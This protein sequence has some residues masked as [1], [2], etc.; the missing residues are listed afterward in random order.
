MK[1]FFR[2]AALVAVVFGFLAQVRGQTPAAIPATAPT[3]E[4]TTAPAPPPPYRLIMPPGMQQVKVGGRVAI[5]PAAMVAAVT[6]GLGTVKPSSRPSTM[7]SDLLTRLAASRATIIAQMSADL[8]IPQDKVATFLDGPLKKD[9]TELAGINAKIYVIVATQADVTAAEKAGWHAPLFYY[10]AMADQTV[11]Q[12]RVSVPLDR[13]MDDVV[14]WTPVEA[15]ATDA[16]IAD[17]LDRTIQDFETG[18]GES[19]AEDG[20]VQTRDDMVRFIAEEVTKNLKVPVDG[21][22]FGLG[23]LGASSAKYMALMTGIPRGDLA[24]AAASDSQS[25]PVKPGPIDLMHPIAPTDI[26]PE[27]IPYYVDAM[28]RKGAG[29]VEYLLEKSKSGD[30]V[31][32]KLLKAINTQQPADN[33]ALLKIIQD[34]SGVDLSG[35]L[36]PK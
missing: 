32:P 28:S 8:N 35:E 19:T 16:D 14:L 11:Y 18:F 3:T 33:A 2:V 26:K 15:S 6:K 36:G 1:R 10:N 9:L 24:A 21:D 7:P 17:A 20:L 22:W 12:P 27:Y 30:A 13:E 4:P 29:A 25:N 31:I 34:V 23:L 5:C